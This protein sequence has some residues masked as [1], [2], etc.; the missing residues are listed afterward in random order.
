MNK[1]DD[2]ENSKYDKFFN[3]NQR[4][5]E[6]NKKIDV[7]KI[8]NEIFDFLYKGKYADKLFSKPNNFEENLVL[9]N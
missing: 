9:K 3:N 2:F 5:A 6:E 4:S 7:K 8:V 1:T